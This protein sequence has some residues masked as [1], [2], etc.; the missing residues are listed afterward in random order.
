MKSSNFIRFS[1]LQV[2]IFRNL[3]RILEE[4]SK[5]FRNLIEVLSLVK[6][7]NRFGRNHLVEIGVVEQLACVS[8]RP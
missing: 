4:I 2:I 6:V 1:H 8:Y 3:I 7:G 5:I